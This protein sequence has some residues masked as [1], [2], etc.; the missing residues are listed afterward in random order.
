MKRKKE[1]NVY[2]SRTPPKLG[3]V[4]ATSFLAFFPKPLFFQR[5]SPNSLEILTLPV[6][7]SFL[8]R[9]KSLKPRR[10]NPKRTLVSLSLSLRPTHTHTYK[11][12]EKLLL[13]LLLSLPPFLFPLQIKPRTQNLHA[14]DLLESLRFFFVASSF[15]LQARAPTPRAS[16][17]L[18]N[19]TETKFDVINVLIQKQFVYN[20]FKF[21]YECCLFSLNI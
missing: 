8:I 3:S 6:S 1:I 16:L 20:N 11:K 14:K 5:S 17:S 2:R 15:L 21:F 9:P 19:F 12:E 4:S 10:M 13:S 7:V 18:S